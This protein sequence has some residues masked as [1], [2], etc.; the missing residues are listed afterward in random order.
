MKKILLTLFVLLLIFIAYLF[1]NVY[2]FTSN[3]LA[4]EGIEKVPTPVGAVDRFVEALSFRTI[5]FE[6][7]ADFDSSQFKQFN[8]FLENSYPLIYGQLEHTLFSEFSHLYHW[9]GSDPTLKPIILMAH[10]DVVPIASPRAWSV[11][12]FTAGLV[13]E[14]IYGRGTMDCKFG[15]VAIMESVEQLLKEGFNP[16]RDIYI[17]LGHD[18]EVLGRKGAHKIAQYLKNKGVEAHYVLDEGMAITEGLVMGV[19]SPI[20]MIGIAEKGFI[21]LEL[22]IAMAGGHSSTPAKETAIDVLSTAVSKVKANPFPRSFNPVIKAFMNKIGPEMDF[23]AKFVFA[24]RRVFNTIL[25][26]EYEKTGSGSATIR[27]TTSPTIFEAGIKENVIPTTARAVINF[28][29]IP[30]ET[31]KEVIAY[32]RNLVNDDRI[33]IEA[34][35][36]GSDPSPISPVDTDQYEAIER[37]IKQILPEVKSAPYLVL[38]AT[39]SRY[40]NI[41]TPNVYRFSPFFINSKN[42]TCFHGIDER[43]PKSEFENGIRFYRQVILNTAVE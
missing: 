26:N 12:P 9:K 14:V 17:S 40:F 16:K 32:V 35:S 11:H 13:D 8:L 19:E 42:L 24:N 6:E 18:E 33:N 22:N 34:L 20:A 7:E 2:N 37:S 21:S 23:K 3:Q 36:Q 1:F 5:S 39:D 4:V 27:T 41:L 38:G 28:R 10:L 43:V 30:G 31:Q 29:I 25:L 15:V